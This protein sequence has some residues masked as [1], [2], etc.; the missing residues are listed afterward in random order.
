MCSRVI[1]TTFISLRSFLICL[2]FNE[3]HLLLF[4]ALCSSS[5]R[6]GSLVLRPCHFPSYLPLLLPLSPP[7]MPPLGGH[8]DAPDWRSPL[9][10]IPTAPHPTVALRYTVTGA[11]RRTEIFTEPRPRVCAISRCVLSAPDNAW[12]K[13]MFNKHQRIDSW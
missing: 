13:V 2:G 8:R 9:A 3:S 10:N 6:R 5:E 1:I 12:H 11:A 4:L 7:I